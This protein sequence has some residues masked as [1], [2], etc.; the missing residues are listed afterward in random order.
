MIIVKENSFVLLKSAWNGTPNIYQAPNAEYEYF[1]YVIDF[2]I[3]NNVLRNDSNAES[4]VIIQNS[5][6]KEKYELD[7][8]MGSSIAEALQNTSKILTDYMLKRAWY[9]TSI[10]A[11]E[12]QMNDVGCALAL[13]TKASASQLED[14]IQESWVEVCCELTDCMLSLERGIKVIE[15]LERDK[16]MGINVT[17][18][19][20]IFWLNCFVLGINLTT[21]AITNPFFHLFRLII[22]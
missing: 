8:S 18:I 15:I 9:T 13:A 14:L 19:V 1:T 6:T 22:C 11:A 16:R 3:K 5:T 21:I 2:L 12:T 20:L 7:I 10:D 17:I 4:C